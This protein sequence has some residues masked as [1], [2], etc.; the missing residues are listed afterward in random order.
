MERK[1]SWFRDARK[2]KGKLDDRIRV[3]HS[4]MSVADECRFC[5]WL[6]A[7][8]YRR[9]SIPVAGITHGIDATAKEMCDHHRRDGTLPIAL[10]ASMEGGFFPDLPFELSFTDP[11]RDCVILGRLDQLLIE[12]GGLLAPLDH[13]SCKKPDEVIRESRLKQM[14]LYAL[15][16]GHWD[17]YA[18]YG[19][20]PRGYLM[21]HYPIFERGG[22]PGAGHRLAIKSEV[23]TVST[24]PARALDRVD[25]VL[26]IVRGPKPPRSA[27]C[28]FCEWALL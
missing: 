10:R 27:D 26:D 18:G 1:I 5:G 16:L 2:E 7:R 24:D 14:D 4:L 12:K 19:V 3:S 20:S 17:A 22:G 25:R 11:A 23:R 13:K 28:P 9:P 6:H 21:F 8:G 15:V